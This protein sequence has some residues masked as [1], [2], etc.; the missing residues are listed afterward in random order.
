MDVYQ[1]VIRLKFNIFVYL[2]VDDKMTLTIWHWNVCHQ[3][4]TDFEIKFNLYPEQ[5]VKFVT[6]TLSLPLIN[7][8]EILISFT[9]TKNNNTENERNALHFKI[10]DI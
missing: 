9:S 2:N 7:T 8:R 10:Q 4:H 1:T 3:W 6:I 5:S